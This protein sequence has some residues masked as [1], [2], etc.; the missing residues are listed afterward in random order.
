METVDTRRIE[1]TATTA[2]KMALLRCP[3]LE[4]YISENDR[5]PSWDGTVFVYPNKTKN[6]NDG[7]RRVPVQVKGTTKKFSQEAKHSCRVGDLRRYYED[8]GCIFFL[9]SVDLNTGDNE[10]FYKSMLVFDLKQILD[11]AGNQKSFTISFDK[12]PANDST[13]IAAIF[14]SYADNFKK[15][16]S[17]INKE[18]HSLDE[19]Q[20]RGVTIESLSFSASGVGLNDSNIGRFISSH[21]FYLYAKPKGLDIEIPIERITNA[22][23]T[24]MITGVV[25]VKGTVYYSSYQV[26][27][28]NGKPVLKI[29]KGINIITKEESNKITGITINITPTGTLSDMIKDTSCFVDVVD[30]GEITIKG[31]R[32]PLRITKGMDIEK[33][34]QRLQYYKDVK[35][36]LDYLG[37][38]EELDCSNLSEND[39]KNIRNFVNAILYNKGIGFPGRNESTLYGSFK[40]A[41]LNIWIWAMQQTDGTYKINSFFTPHEMALFSEADVEMVCPMPITQY[42]LLTAE[43]FA[44]ASNMD[45]K[46]VRNDITSRPPDPRT[47]DRV[48]ELQLNVLNG[49]DI[50]TEKDDRLLDL[51]EAIGAWLKESYERTDTHP[52]GEKL[53]QLQ[54]VRRRRELYA[55]EIVE[56]S[57][58]ADEKNPPNIR[59][60]AYLLLEEIGE[61][62]KCFD[63]LPL[64]EQEDFI[65]YP[66]CHFGE[67]KITGT[68]NTNKEAGT[69]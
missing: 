35:R 54:I 16:M 4:S 69:E 12:F 42:V 56:L 25:S 8:G 36:M 18:L 19:L 23:A 60:G 1:E 41:N 3:Y 34:R 30:N 48:T 49:Y 5:T 67:L 27:Y 39:E 15:Q 9:V 2:V 63:Q 7:V 57:K 29:G 32:F 58:L 13:E 37:V 51:A 6:I 14:F 22:I 33:Y 62:Q 55:P 24:R 17:F 31:V 43:A 59:C 53:N 21:D 66:I 44:R 64:A 20:K 68:E 26:T 28:K 47:T 38:H 50:Q 61:A 52:Q 11:K 45:Y 40:I 65:K 46:V 10:I